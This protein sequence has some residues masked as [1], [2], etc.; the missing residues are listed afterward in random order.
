MS[1]PLLFQIFINATAFGT[2][3]NVKKFMNS[4]I[5][6]ALAAGAAQSIFASPAELVKIWQQNDGVGRPYS[7]RSFG[8]P[9][10]VAKMIGIRGIYKGFSLTLLRD[11]PGYGIYFYAYGTIK[12]WWVVPN[13]D[14]TPLDFVKFA[15]AGGFA[16][17]ASY[18][19]YFPD[20]FK[21]NY[22][23]DG[24]RGTMPKYKG[25]VDC[26]ISTHR[27]REV[28]VLRFYVWGPGMGWSLARAFVNGFFLL[29]TV[30]AVKNILL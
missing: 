10:E 2:E 22:Q 25:V 7:Q 5:L 29:P 11:V 17:A 20:V 21:T 3:E 9:Y 24:A 23:N 8:R 14:L 30:E 15:F 28:S 18:L 16:G 19:W 1:W 13:K 26:I 27:A 6:G 4:Q 12:T